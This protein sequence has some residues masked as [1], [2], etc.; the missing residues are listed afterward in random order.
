MT[1]APWVA[2][3][4][5]IVA[6]FAVTAGSVLPNRDSPGAGSFVGLLAGLGTLTVMVLLFALDVLPEDSVRWLILTVFAV[7]V[8]VFLAWTAFA[9]AFTGRGP[10]LTRRRVGGLGA[11]WVLTVLS[12]VVTGNL[13]GS[14]QIVSLITTSVLQ[15]GVVVFPVFGVFVAARS[16]IVYGDLPTG[17]AAT[18]VGGGLLVTLLVV[19]LTFLGVDNSEVLFSVL[20]VHLGV[21]AAVFL[22]AQLRYDLL[23][24]PPIAGHLARETVLDTMSD[25]VV[26]VDREHRILDAN[27]AAERTFGIDPTDASVQSTAETVGIDAET[28]LGEPLPLE[29]TAGRRQ[30]QVSRTSLSEGRGTLVGYA[31]RLRDV[32]DRRTREQRLEVLNRVLRHNLRNDL[33]AVRGF[34]EP[35]LTPDRRS[36]ADVADLAGRIRTTADDL[37]EIGATVE[38]AERIRSRDPPERTEID[39]VELAESVAADIEG[40]EVAV[41]DTEA[42]VAI[43]TDPAVLRTAL[44]E[45][46]TNAVEHGDREPPAVEIGVERTEGGAAIE[47]RDEGPG[48]PES[49]IEVIRKGSET[50]LDHGSGLGLWVANWAVTDLGGE[51]SFRERDPR[52]SVV[53]VT[54]PARATA[55]DADRTGT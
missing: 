23:D 9:V 17:R 3:G 42:P 18:L 20:L 37:A 40:G 32:T 29:T 51:I 43:T 28:D 33:D 55:S 8:F 54:L 34:A 35:L 5:V 6:A 30:F 46:V 24:D 50:A 48:I 45:L 1:G 36:D 4:G 31:Y 16:S 10:A 7:S 26:V 44:D 52:G 2:A 47:I 27:R 53:R 25:A 41:T 38:R 21:I 19:P 13:S 22:V 11:L 49:E 15:L 12:T 39:P 14:V